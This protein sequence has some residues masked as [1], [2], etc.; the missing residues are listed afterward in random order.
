M[1]QEPFHQYILDA[2]PITALLCKTLICSGLSVNALDENKNTPLHILA[3]EANK[4]APSDMKNHYDILTCL[5]ENG[6]HI[7]ACN[8]LG[9]TAIDVA[10]DDTI[11]EMIKTHKK[12]NLKCLAAKVIKKNGISFKNCLP[13]YFHE[14][15]DL[16]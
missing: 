13:E 3:S 8:N 5:I 1:L 4:V 9:E 11:K 6:A 15:V 10:T 16:H 12:I 7:D 14:Y 2:Y